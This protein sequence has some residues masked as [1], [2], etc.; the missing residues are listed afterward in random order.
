MFYLKK[1]IAVIESEKHMEAVE[2][3]GLV[4]K[5]AGME[6]VCMP[7]KGYQADE[8]NADE[9]I[10]CLW[11]ADNAAIIKRLQ[12]EGQAV[13]AF[14]HE[15]NRNQDFSAVRYAC[16]EPQELDADYMD[17]VFR[18]CMRLP[19]DILQTKRCFVRETVPEDVDSFYEI[20]SEPS[21]TRYTEGLLPEK[22]QE[23]QYINDYIDA[24]YSFYNCGVWTVVND[25]TDEIIGRAGLS[26]REGYETPELGFV[27]GTRWQRQ[28]YAEEVC[29]AILQYGKEELGFEE[30]QAFVKPENQASVALCKKLGFEQTGE[31]LLGEEKHWQLVCRL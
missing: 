7:W 24:V 31:A 28:G 20:Y 25:D 6:F 16:E 30:V 4:L 13:L 22:E 3:L 5:A 26:Y 29:R 27:I 23:Q 2:Q 19:W 12:G 17:K 10:P 21:I 1:V 14:L 15:D 18:R 9:Y 8:D 11:F